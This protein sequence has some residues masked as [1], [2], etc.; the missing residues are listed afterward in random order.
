MKANPIAIAYSWRIPNGTRSTHQVNWTPENNAKII[1]TTRFIANPINEP[2]VVDSTMIVFG[3]LIFRRISP[4]ST[5]ERIPT[6]VASEKKLHNEI[7]RSNTIGNVGVPSVN[8]R[9]RTNTIYIT[10]KSASGFS[11]DHRIPRIEP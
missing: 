4:L 6:L 11:T 7:P 2:V 3:K 8:L 1:T 5:I 9:N 10:K